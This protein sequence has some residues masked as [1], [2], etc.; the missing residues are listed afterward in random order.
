MGGSIILEKAVEAHLPL[1]VRILEFPELLRDGKFPLANGR[2]I[3]N[4]PKI[5]QLDFSHFYN[6]HSMASFRAIAKQPRGS[7]SDPIVVEL[8]S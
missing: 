4:I 2:N 7:K 6:L 3:T 5:L 8:V 1:N